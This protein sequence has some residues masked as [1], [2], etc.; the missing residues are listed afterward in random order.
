[1][2]KPH[3]LKALCWPRPWEALDRHKEGAADF[4]RSGVLQ[5]ILRSVPSAAAAGCWSKAESCSQG[6][7]CGVQLA[8]AEAQGREQCLGPVTRI[9]ISD[10]VAEAAPNPSWHRR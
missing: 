10:G 4:T 7:R 3:D 9:G 1:M 5:G 8:K 6:G 2:G